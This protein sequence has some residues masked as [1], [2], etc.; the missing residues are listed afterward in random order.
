[1]ACWTNNPPQVEVFAN[2]SYQNSRDR[3]HERQADQDY[4]LGERFYCNSVVY[5]YGGQER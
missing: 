5:S 3:E 4:N 2:F 1:M